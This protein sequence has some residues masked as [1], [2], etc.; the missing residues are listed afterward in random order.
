MSR[1]KP[2]PTRI[3]VA[4]SCRTTAASLKTG[5][6]KNL[7]SPA[8]FSGWR[9]HRLRDDLSYI[10]PLHDDQQVRIFAV[11]PSEDQANDGAE[12][13]GA[14]CGRTREGNHQPGN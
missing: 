5:F 14:K 4:V 8:L 12:P 9:S 10:D 1:L 13:G 3:L 2:R 6:R 7:R 11:F